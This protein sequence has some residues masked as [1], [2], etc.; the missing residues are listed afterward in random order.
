MGSRG[1]LPK[2]DNQRVNRKPRP[3]LRVVVNEKAEQPPL[4]EQTF[5]WPRKTREWR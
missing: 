5:D 2:P 1:P 4:D 3:D